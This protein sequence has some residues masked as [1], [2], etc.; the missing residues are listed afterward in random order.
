M[1]GSNFLFDFLSTRWP[2][3]ITVMHC[4]MFVI[5][6]S[7]LLYLGGLFDLSTCDEALQVSEL[8]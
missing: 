8:F 5:I 2:F 6:F 3:Y 1:V 7:P 4:T